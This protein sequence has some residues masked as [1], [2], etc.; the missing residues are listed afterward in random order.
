MI[1]QCMLNFTEHDIS[2]DQLAFK[3]SDDIN[4]ML[5]NVKMPTIVSILTILS[6]IY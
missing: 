5:L 3:L 1:K 4:I 6:M 2:T